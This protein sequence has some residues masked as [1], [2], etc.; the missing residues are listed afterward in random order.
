MLGNSGILQFYVAVSYVVGMDGAEALQGRGGERDAGRAADVL[1]PLH[2]ADT[3]LE[4]TAEKSQLIFSITLYCPF[5]HLLLRRATKHLANGMN[6]TKF[7]KR[8]INTTK[9]DTKF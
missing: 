5:M 1:H 2:L 8:V 4:H 3:P 7:P 9:K 6:V